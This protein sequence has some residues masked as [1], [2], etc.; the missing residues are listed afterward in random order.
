MFR[1]R[2]LN[3]Y[4]SGVHLLTLSE[5]VNLGKTLGELAAGEWICH[6]L[7]AFEIAQMAP[8]GAAT[9]S[10]F[11]L[12]D[13]S[14]PNDKPVLVMRS[15]AIGDLLLLSPC[16]TE[17]AR[18]TNSVFHLC[19][20]ARHHP[21]FNGER[22]LGGLVNYPLTA[23]EAWKYREIISLENTMESDHSQHATDVFAKALGLPTPLPDYRPVYRVADEERAAT[24]KHLF[25]TRPNIVI[26]PKASVANRD[27]PFPLW[28]EVIQK[29][30]SQGWGVLILG[31]KG[32]IPPL[33]PVL[34]TPFVRDLSTTG[35]SLRESAAVLSQAQ[36]FCGVDSAFAHLCH[37]LDI[38]AVV[39]FAAFDWKTRTSKAPKTIAL[40]GVGEC[41][42]CNWHMHAGRQFP[43]NKPCTRVKVC[44]VLASIPPERIVSKIQLLKP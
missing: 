10:R 9:V 1:Q 4:A 3:E 33:P 29:L 42:P 43:P 27:Y 38:P 28:S 23:S 37:A 30:E 16:F 2:L 8:R 31:R 18:Q 24:K 40:T 44:T 35:L 34:Q 6:D 11:V 17:W 19:C 15:G 14:E 5:P 13:R 25:T 36:A 12:P 21:I 26:Q 7:N 22:W 39:L 20:F 41:A 32:Q